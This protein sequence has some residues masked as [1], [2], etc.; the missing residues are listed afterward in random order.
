NQLAIAA[1]GV[2][3]EL[4]AP[5]DRLAGELELDAGQEDGGGAERGSEHEH[6]GSDP[7]RDMVPR[8]SRGPRQKLSLQWTR[9]DERRTRLGLGVTDPEGPTQPAHPP[10]QGASAAPPAHPPGQGAPAPRPTMDS[11]LALEAVTP[12]TSARVETLSRHFVGISLRRA[13]RLQI[14]TDEVLP[15]ERA[16]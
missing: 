12:R 9:M 1:R 2:Q 8:H 3:R 5:R 10:G 14:R 15:S 7:H 11:G 16:H 6:P 13:F 4:G